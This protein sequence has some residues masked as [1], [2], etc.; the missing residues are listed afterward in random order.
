MSVRRRSAILG[1]SF[2]YAS[3]MISLA[4]NILFIPIYLHNIPMVEFGAWLATG[5]ALALLLINDFGLSGVVIQK[6][7]SSFGA[8]DLETIGSLAGSA[9]VIGTFMALTLTGISLALLPF[10]PGLQS[11][12]EL[13][14]HTVVNCFLIA[15][16]A[17]ALGLVGATVMSIV[18]SLQR[19]VPA[20]S[21]VLVA[22]LMN[23][24]V[25]LVGLY[26]G[27]G[28]YS[29][30]LGMLARSIILVLGGAGAVAIVCSRIVPVSIVVKWRAV[31]ELLGDS[32]RFFLTSIAMK[33]QSQA[34]IV[35]VSAILGP[36]SA[37]VYALTIRAHETV[38]MLIGQINS[39][40]MPSVTHLFGSG[41]ITRF[42]AVLLRLLL[43]L[44]LVT[45]FALTTTVILNRGFLHLWLVNQNFVGQD[46]S[47]LMAIALFFSSLGYVAYDALVSQGKFKYVS[48]VLLMSSL[49]QVLLLGCLLR[50]GMWLAPAATLITALIWGSL[51]WRTVREGIDLTAAEA[52]GLLAE[53]ARIVGFSVVTATA[54]NVFYP[55]A[56]SWR[57]LIAEGLLCMTVLIVGY[58]LFSATFLKIIREEIGMTLNAFRPNR[59]Y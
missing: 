1:M 58:L 53:V 12:S 32:S 3:L 47:I 8:G 37:G 2:G 45:A 57:G 4:R 17:N 19:A 27:N 15:V 24:T 13:Q 18:R 31:G 10:L 41:D 29:I 35:F 54:F 43:A 40:L 36:S 33:M 6:I 48:R 50:F 38:M 14:R 46:V 30:A 51:F 28:L 42:R 34:T 52:R 39:A 9:I 21:V 11:L 16:A 20:G 22:D 44:S 26:R 59:E 49:L 56:V 23:V 25:T 55:T 7:S 5:G